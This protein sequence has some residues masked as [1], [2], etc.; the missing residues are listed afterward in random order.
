MVHIKKVYVR[1][2]NEGNTI[3]LYSTKEK[4]GLIEIENYPKDYPQVPMK[5]IITEVDNEYIFTIVPE[6]EL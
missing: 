4:D 3:E 5:Y 2:T 6:W 1:L